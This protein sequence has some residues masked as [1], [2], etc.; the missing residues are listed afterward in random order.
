MA[1][2]GEWRR[3]PYLISDD[4][5]RLDVDFIHG[6]IT[7]SYW[8]GGRSFDAVRRSIEGSLALGLYDGDEQVGFARVITDYATKAHLCDI[9]VIDAYKG[10]GLGKWLIEC[11]LGHPRLSSISAYSCCVRATYG[12][13]PISVAICRAFSK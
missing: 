11:A 12:L 8:A 3:G 9:F 4:P 6:Y 1:E 2:P 7:A 10:Q 13:A 5:A